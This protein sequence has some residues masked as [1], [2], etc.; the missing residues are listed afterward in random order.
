M[1]NIKPAFEKVN[2]EFG[3]SLLVKQHNEIA[4]NQLPFWHFHPGSGSDHYHRK[5]HSQP[6]F[7]NPAQWMEISLLKALISF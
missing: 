5:Y 1:R 4:E 6:G 7:V 2:P 3:N